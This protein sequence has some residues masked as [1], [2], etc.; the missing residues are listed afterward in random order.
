MKILPNINK[1]TYT[2][3]ITT[4]NLISFFGASLSIIIFSI[5]NILKHHELVDS[6]TIL[7][8][9]YVIA[10]ILMIAS[11]V[12]FFGF[13]TNK[14]Y[15][16]HK[17]NYVSKLTEEE[18]KIRLK[19]IASRNYVLYNSLISLA[20]LCKTIDE[21]CGS[22][23]LVNFSVRG[24][25]V[26]IVFFFPKMMAIL[27]IIGN[28]SYFRGEGPFKGIIKQYLKLTVITTA[29]STFQFLAYDPF[30]LSL[31]ISNIVQIIICI[32]DDKCISIIENKNIEI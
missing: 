21:T 17:D 4:K 29:M 24:I 18:A 20:A 7:N 13:V 5:G 16:E 11:I 6:N 1:Q 14:R 12:F 3:I 31:L 27:A 9:L 8:V 23:N 22:L 2:E 30:S 26:F 19:N 28:I 15:K 10:I 25:S 32:I